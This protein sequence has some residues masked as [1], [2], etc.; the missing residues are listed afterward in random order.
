[1]ALNRNHYG[2]FS[3][4]PLWE[5]TEW[6]NST[7]L[8]KNTFTKIPFEGYAVEGS[9]TN[10]FLEGVRA[11]YSSSRFFGFPWVSLKLCTNSILP[12]CINNLGS[13]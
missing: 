9:P 13:F 1:M 7:C 6:K 8:K 10:T 12:K 11:Q 4:L 5:A 2:T 3:K